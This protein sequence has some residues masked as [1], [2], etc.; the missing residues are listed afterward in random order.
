MQ[1]LHNYPG[2]RLRYG[3]QARQPELHFEIIGE[4]QLGTII[5]SPFLHCRPHD[6]SCG[7]CGVA[8]LSPD[9]IS[10]RIDRPAVV[11]DSRTTRRGAVPPAAVAIPASHK[12]D[13]RMPIKKR[14]H[15][16]QAVR[17]EEIVGAEYHEIVPGG[18]IN[19]LV[20]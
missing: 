7:D 6:R 17:Q 8:A 14:K 2:G 1:S 18:P 5:T 3:T 19:A 20:P 12:T 15:R 11:W 16:R 10:S 4:R 13:F 9:E